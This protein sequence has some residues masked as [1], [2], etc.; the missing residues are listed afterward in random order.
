MGYLRPLIMY[1]PPLIHL[2]P[3]DWAIAFLVMSLTFASHILR[4]MRIAGDELT[5][6]VDWLRKLRRRLRGKH[7]SHT[8]RRGRRRGQRRA[9]RLRSRP[10]LTGTKIP[11]PGNHLASRKGQAPQDTAVGREPRL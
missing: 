2:S 9:P 7:S 5:D 3:L 1:L 8:R 10:N 6:F 11:P 4:L